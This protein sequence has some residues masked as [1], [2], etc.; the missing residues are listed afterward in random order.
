MA[1]IDGVAQL[2]L[3]LLQPPAFPRPQRPCHDLVHD[4]SPRQPA[5]LT[6]DVGNLFTGNHLL[7][8]R[9]GPPEEAARN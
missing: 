4:G 6:A 2:P 8:R 7:A 5:A 3:E 1:A 9:F